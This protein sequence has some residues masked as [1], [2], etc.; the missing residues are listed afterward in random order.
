MRVHQKE[1][2]SSGEIVLLRLPKARHIG[3]GDRALGGE[4][5]KDRCCGSP[6]TVRPITTPIQVG[7]DDRKGTFSPRGPTENDGE[8]CR[9]QAV[10]EQSHLVL[11]GLLCPCRMKQ[12]WYVVG[13]RFV[14]AE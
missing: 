10:S 2:H 11:P 4:E 14:A 5:H 12:Y 3:V 6:Q 9:Q 1:P 8:E 13:K 7:P